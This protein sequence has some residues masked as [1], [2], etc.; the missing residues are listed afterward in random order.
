MI[1]IGLFGY[2][3]LARGAEC[4][5]RQNSDMKLTCV[6]TRRDPKTVN[7]VFGD[8][9]VYQCLSTLVSAGYNGFVTVEFEGMED[10]VTGT[11]YGL[12]TLK[13]IFESIG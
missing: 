8:V 9:P 1:K 5:I 12:N 13:R 2:G 7:T 4:A 11:T 10:P 3:N 6:F